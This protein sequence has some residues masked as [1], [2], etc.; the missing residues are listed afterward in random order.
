M[1]LFFFLAR[2]RTNNLDLM[3]SAL[4][5]HTDWMGLLNKREIDRPQLN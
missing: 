4:E 5:T 1:N 3:G 2:G